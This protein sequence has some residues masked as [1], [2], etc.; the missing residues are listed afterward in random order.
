M[1]K[2]ELIASLVEQTGKPPE[3]VAALVVATFNRLAEALSKQ[4]K[5]TIPGFG[6]FATKRRAERK[7][8][9]PATG[10]AIIIPQAVI[11]Q[12]KPATPLK[13]LLNSVD[14]E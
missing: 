1:T 5:V 10:K 12:F 2:T 14:H 6:T 8:R 3:E 13:D 9:N 11:V 7:G 4:E